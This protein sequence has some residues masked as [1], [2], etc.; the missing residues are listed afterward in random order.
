MGRIT[1]LACISALVLSSCLE[2][3]T[4]IRLKKNDTVTTRLVY[5]IAP[6]LADFGRGFGSDEP[7]PLPLTKKDFDQQALRVEGVEIVRYRAHKLA[8]ESERIDVKLAAKSLDNIANY[9]ALDFDIEREGEGGS[10]VFT[11]PLVNGYEKTDEER[12]EIIDAITEDFVFRFSFEPPSKP[13]SVFPG[14]IEGK[15]ATL[16]VSL[17]ELLYNKAPEVWKVNW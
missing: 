7:W 3:E 4:I 12:R 6:E 15:T 13:V 9:L 5:T 17:Q 2:L 14:E 8:D 1:S 11:L 16:E 10:F